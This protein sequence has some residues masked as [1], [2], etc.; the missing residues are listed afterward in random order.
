MRRNKSL[1]MHP[2][3]PSPFAY[4]RILII[5]LV[6][7]A[8]FS[9]ICSC[10][11]D[12]TPK[13]SGY[14]RIDLP[15]KKYHLFNPP[16]CPFEFE[17]PDYT[18][19]LPDTGRFAEPCWY[20]VFFKQFDGRIHL[21]YKAVGNNLKKHL[22]DSRTLAYK[23]SSKADAID[24]ILIRSDDGKATGIL[25]H[26]AG[27]AA[28]SVQFYVTD[29]TANFLR[30]AL[31]FNSPPQSDSLMPVILFCEKDIN[32]LIKTLRWKNN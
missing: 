21:S 9:L 29:S 5:G 15:E 28:S 18:V 7:M 11:H 17:I 26:I 3:I 22:E 10:T 12:Y 23:H 14:F 31:Y 20:D 1:Q 19:A 27:N 30:G 16:E 13:P 2:G 24:E 8:I 25:Y 32:H 6:T 4:R